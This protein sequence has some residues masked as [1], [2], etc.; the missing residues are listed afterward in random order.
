MDD[1]EYQAV[2]KKLDMPMFYL[3]GGDL[4]EATRQEAELIGRIV[5]KLGL[6]KK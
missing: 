2:L 3:S 6:Q 4:E 5:Q 1:P